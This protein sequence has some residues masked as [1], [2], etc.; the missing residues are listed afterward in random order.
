ME[1]IVQSIVHPMGHAIVMAIVIHYLETVYVIVD[2]ME[3]DVRKNK[4]L[5][6]FLI[7]TLL[8]M[9]RAIN[10]KNETVIEHLTGILS[11]RNIHPIII[12]NTSPMDVDGGKNYPL[13]EQLVI[14]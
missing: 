5:M 11:Q 1:V 12:T 13:Q 10:E 8:K 6:G 4:I 14:I 9:N 2:I 7:E 3:R